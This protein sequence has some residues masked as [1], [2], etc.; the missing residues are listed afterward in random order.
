MP[1]GFAPAKKDI[2]QP[3]VE[4]AF[5]QAGWSVCDTHALGEDAPDLFVAKRGR[6]IAVEVKTGKKKRKPHQVAW[7]NNWNGRYLWGSDPLLLLEM[8]ERELDE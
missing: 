6:T 8:A 4:K 3:A 5:L 1:R 2:A 7:A